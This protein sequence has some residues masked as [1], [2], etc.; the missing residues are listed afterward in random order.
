MAGWGTPAGA[1]IA[2]MNSVDASKACPTDR[3][4]P[5]RAIVGLGR[6]AD[7]PGRFAETGQIDSLLAADS[8]MSEVDWLAVPL[9]LVLI[10]GRRPRL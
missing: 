3:H 8:E 10:A 1:A 4:G 9:Y 5:R 2:T 7:Q 6:G